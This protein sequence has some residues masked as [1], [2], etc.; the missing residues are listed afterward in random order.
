MI[1]DNNIGRKIKTFRKK[2]GL[3][4]KKLAEQ[5]I[6]KKEK[7][8]ETSGKVAEGLAALAEGM[9]GM[10]GGQMSKGFVGQP[11]GASQVP[12]TRVGMAD[13]GLMDL[14]SLIDQTPLSEEEK[15]VQKQLIQLQLGQQTL[16]NS[17]QYVASDAPYK[18]VYRPYFSEVTKAYNAAKKTCG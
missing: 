13:G 16:T 18:A 9:G 14:L 5:E 8:K 2:L 10:G 12:F 6:D 17:P 1:I 15:A 11:I 7:R 4:A 3:Q